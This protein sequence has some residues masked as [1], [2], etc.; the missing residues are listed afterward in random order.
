[1]AAVGTDYG[2]SAID[3][4]NYDSTNGRSQK[5]YGLNSQSFGLNATQKRKRPGALHSTIREEEKEVRGSPF[6]PDTAYNMTTVTG[7]QGVRL[8]TDSIG[9]NDSTKM[10]INKKMQCE[11]EYS[12]APEEGV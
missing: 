1:M 6:R 5:G 12:H 2:A 8:E 9:S 10:I 7:G 3:I 11:V 4:D